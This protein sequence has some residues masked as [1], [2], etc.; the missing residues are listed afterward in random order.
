MNDPTARRVEELFHEAREL[1]RDQREA[2]LVDACRGSDDTLREV[3]QL[4][5]AHDQAGEFL[6]RSPVEHAPWLAFTERV[7]PVA[8]GGDGDVPMRVGRYRILQEIG[9]GGFGAVYMAQQEEPIRRKVALKMLKLGM[10]SKEVIARFEAERQALAMMDHPNIAAV[11]D[12]GTTEAGRPYFVM[13]LVPGIP[14]TEYCDKSQLDVDERLE[15]FVQVCAAVHHA[16]QKGIIHRDIKPSNVLVTLH[17]GEPVPK[18]IDFGIAK[19]TNQRLTDKTYFTRYGQFIGSPS[20][21]SPEQAE[22]S[23]LDVDTRSDVYSLGVLLYELLTGFL[24]FDMDR[25]REAGLV[26]IHRFLRE[27]DP[28]RPST[29][30]STM[31]SRAVTSATRRNTDPERLARSFKGDLDWIVLKALEKD[32]SRRYDTAS[33]L[34]DDVRRYL[35]DDMVT[36][37]PPS[38]QY[39][40]SK[41]IR[42]HRTMSTAIGLVALAVVVGV[43]LA[44]AGFLEARR[45]AQ[46]A[47]TEADRAQEVIT[48]LQEVL[49]PA[50]RHSALAPDITLRQILDDYVER[51]DER[52]IDDPEVEAT[53]RL[54]MGVAYK[55]LGDLEVS[56]AQIARALQLRREVFGENHLKTAETYLDWAW[57]LHDLGRYPEAE[58]AF[59]RSLDLHERLAGDTNEFTGES[60]LGLSDILRHLE[61]FDE[62]RPHALRAVELRRLVFGQ[63]HERVAAA[64]S[65]LSQLHEAEGDFERA[66]QVARE[67]LA[68]RRRTLEPGD[69]EIAISLTALAGIVHKGRGTIE[70]VELLQEAIAIRSKAFGEESVQVAQTRRRLATIHL[71]RVEPEQARLHLVAAH[72][73]LA[74]SPLHQDAARAVARTLSEIESERGDVDSADHWTRLAEATKDPTEFHD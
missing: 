30:V 41:S 68:M 42:R 71:D 38:L 13:E 34:A 26:E 56:Q 50:N 63:E 20:Y 40:M 65:N 45:Q 70:P 33:A 51:V 39:R 23:G 47:R 4:L 11:L 52:A 59:R 9:T 46:V 5:E 43:A 1:P 73:G 25:L 67:A 35:A 14:I 27:V 2:F 31:G 29:R 72:G 8:D 18:V 54:T 17:D 36:A 32:R 74:A 16:H 61:R 19:A 53:L 22:M 44:G 21:M 58:M 6:D 12:A 15:L 24:P 49:S 10:D 3:R 69:P 55:T 57:Q 62:A 48:L 64:L 28:P 7:L 37:R 60:H 66:E